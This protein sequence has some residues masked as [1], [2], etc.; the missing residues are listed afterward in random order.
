M[1]GEL[2]LELH[3]QRAEDARVGAREFEAVGPSATCLAAHVVRAHVLAADDVERLPE[4][5][6]LY[7]PDRMRLG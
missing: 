5:V 4:V 3:G 7:G 6:Y 2:V 1:C